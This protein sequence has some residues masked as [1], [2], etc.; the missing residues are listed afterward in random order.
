MARRGIF[1]PEYYRRV[2]EILSFFS[3]SAD[4]KIW[5]GRAG[6]NV[7]NFLHGEGDGGTLWRGG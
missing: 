4:G 7:P 2:G 1:I 5:I 6:S 3:D